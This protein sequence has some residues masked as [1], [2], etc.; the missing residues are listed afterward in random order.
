MAQAALERCFHLCAERAWRLACALLR[1][2]HEAHD[3][4]QQAFVAA[5]R[6]P[7]RIPRDDPWPW[8]SAV[9][10]HEARN[11][12]RKK[13]PAAA[14]EFEMAD[15]H[16]QPPSA[17]QRAESAEQLRRELERLPEAEREAIALTHITGLTHV[18]A[19]SALGV[20]VK[21]LSSHVTRGLE[22]LRARMGGKEESLMASLAALPALTPPGGWEAALAAWKSASFAALAPAGAA[23]ATGAIMAK[24][25]LVACGLAVALGVGFGG[26]WYLERASQPEVQPQAAPIESASG[27]PAGNPG[28]AIEGGT[29]EPETSGAS[30]GGGSTAPATHNAEAGRLRDELATVKKERD[31]ARS[32]ADRLEAEL[33][34]LRAEQAQ[35]EPTFTFGKYGDIDGVRK[36]NWKELA[37]ANRIVVEC[38]REI[39]TA[40]R[41][42]EQPSREVQIRLQRYTEMVRKYEYETIGV[43]QSFARH[44]GELTHPLTVANMFAAELAARELPLTEAQRK[45][46]ETLGLKFENDFEGAQARYGGTTPRCEKLLDEYLL[47]GAFMDALYD[48]L[49][50]AQRAAMIDPATHR[51]AYCDLHCPTLML[52]HT[53][54]ILTGQDKAELQQKLHDML[55]QRYKF[56]ESQAPVLQPLLDSWAADVAGMLSPVSQA[57]HRFYTYEQGTIAA[58]ATVKLVCAIRD[59]LVLSEEARAALLDSYDI[60]VPRMIG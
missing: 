38:I 48:V 19:A 32:R 39:R 20:P 18:E 37:G 55:K 57:E 25:V 42:G 46:I 15:P 2:A 13:R 1:D 5:A 22:R 27:A 51:I 26:G 34:P 16:P 44:N 49:D 40:Q 54:P 6:K 23:A 59:Q 14:Q 36:S 29:R 17:A 31:E 52:I 50:A 33:A 28:N 60:Y 7:S 11:L 4:V 58:R 41:K 53:S 9:L 12:S 47:K 21:T 35:R 8:F 43:I 3:C 56:D 24:K 30:R 45:Q 10:V